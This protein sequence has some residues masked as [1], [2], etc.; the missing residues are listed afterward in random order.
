MTRFVD[1]GKCFVCSGTNSHGLQ[2]SFRRAAGR[3]EGETVVGEAFQ[4]YAGVVHG[5]VVSAL[6]D[7]A[8][9]YALESV[10]FHGATVE[11]TVRYRRPTPIGQPVR[12]EA[13]CRGVNGRLGKAV[14]TLWQGEVRCAE[15]EGKFLAVEGDS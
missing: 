11:L 1:S 2:V 10:G 12:V 5:G 8:M 9:F 14:A 15:G 7:E 3:A 6:L 4:G 13:E